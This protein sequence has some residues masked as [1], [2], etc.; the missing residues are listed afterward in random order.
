MTFRIAVALALVAG[1]LSTVTDALAQPAVG[2][3][4]R[5]KTAKVINIAYSPDSIPF[6]V[7][8]DGEAVGYSIDLCKRVVQQIG[9]AIDEPNL[10]VNWIPGS[11]TERLAMVAA[12]KADMEC[13]NTTLTQGRLATVDFSNLIFVESGGFLVRS[14]GTVD[15]NGELGGKRIG[16]LKG[17]TTE[18]RLKE[19]FRRRMV[20]AT[21]VPINGAVEGIAMLESGTIDAYA[22]DK[23]K[24]IGLAATS[25]EPS[26]FKLLPV[27]ISY[28]P[29][30]LALP[31]GDSAFRLEVNKALTRA[32][33]SSEIE[34]IFAKWMGKLGQPSS[35]LSALYLL[36]SIPE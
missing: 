28:E 22:G 32:Y 6:S 29:Y 34:G 7:K 18:S 21:V 11:V 12:G 10:K 20:N 27:D 4:G 13:A 23:L 15:A 8:E 16:V 24:L 14:N 25:K 36:N 3:L 19:A 35:L 17:T 2:T 5:I 1:M 26:M 30:A 31:R 9:R 33:A